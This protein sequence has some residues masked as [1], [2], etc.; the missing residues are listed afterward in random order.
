MELVGG[1]YEQILF[2]FA[3]RPR[4][5]SFLGSHC[6]S[7][8]GERGGLAWIFLKAST[9]LFLLEAIEPL[10]TQHQSIPITSHKNWMPIPD[11][12]HHAHTASLSAVAVNNRYVVTGSRDETIQIYDMKKKIEHGALLHHNGTIT[13]LEFYG[14]A[15][16]LSAAEDGLICIWDTKRWE[17]LKSIKAH[18]GHVTSLS[19]HPSGKL[20]LSVGTDKTLRTWNLVEGRS[21]FIKN[22][23]QNAHIVKWSPNGEKYVVIVTNKVDIYKLETASVSGAITTEKRISS[24]RFI[25][26]S[27]LAIAGDDEVIRLY[28]CDS[29]KCLCEFKAHENRIKDIY[30]F[31]KEGLQVIVTASSDGYIKLWSLELDKIQDS[32]SLLCEVNTKARLTCLAVWLDRTSETKENPD[33]ATTSSYVNEDEP[34]LITRKKKVCWTDDSDKSAKGNRQV[35]PKKRKSE[36]AQQKKKM[37]LQS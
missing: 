24:V 12:T 14:N 34:P 26:D 8:E 2:G 1:C 16:L 36:G 19:I 31:E 9:C 20:A 15:Y 28:D 32:P 21:A 3:V 23:K 33:T 29:Q 17:C 6:Q 13:C 27:V 10:S 22:L 30:S 7:A 4:E 37:K 35:T 11:F 5:Y 18:K 25:T